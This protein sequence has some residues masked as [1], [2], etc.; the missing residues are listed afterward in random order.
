MLKLQSYIAQL[1]ISIARW[2]GAGA[3]AAA[4]LKKYNIKE[5]IAESLFPEQVIKFAEYAFY[6]G[7]I[8]TLLYG[9]YRHT[10]YH[11]DI[12][13]AYPS[14]MLQLPS[15]AHGE[16]LHVTTLHTRENVLESPLVGLFKVSWRYTGDHSKAVLCPFPW[17]SKMGYVYFPPAGT[18]WVWGPEVKMCLEHM[19]KGRFKFDVRI[20]ESWQFFPDEDVRPFYFIQE[21]YDLRKEYVKQKNGAE[22]VIKLGLNSLYGK[23]AQ[24][25]GYREEDGRKPP[26][27]SMVVAGMVTSMTRAKMMEAALQCPNDVIMLATDGIYSKKPFDVPGMY[28]TDKVLGQWEVEQHEYM[29][30]VASGVYWYKSVE[31]KENAFSRGFDKYTLIR[32]QVLE[33]W[34]HRVEMLNC[35]TTRFV[36]LGSAIG[37]NSFE[38]WC[39]WRTVV[40]KLGLNMDTV[41][42]RSV[43]SLERT[44]PSQSLVRTYAAIP[45]PFVALEYVPLE[46]YSHKTMSTKYSFGWDVEHIDGVNMR[47]Y[48]DEV[49]NTTA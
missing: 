5:H 30:I 20:T 39:T 46:K 37:L 11:A 21:M 4:F 31:K 45:T 33:A 15:F 29:T 7:R 23:T 17:R 8:E 38:Y 14:A 6:G 1:G 13:S 49:G 32:I 40:R 10:V 41:A 48:L 35:Q 36:G 26:Y 24:S 19:N 43:P 34:K 44:K 9:D 16:W 18:A 42:K 3:I 27:H 2:D 22:K 47:V 25:L 28:S 12:N